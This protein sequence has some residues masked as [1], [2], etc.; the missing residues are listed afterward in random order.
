MDV[1]LARLLDETVQGRSQMTH[2]LRSEIKM[3]AR[4][5]ARRRGRAAGDV[6]VVPRDGPGPARAAPA[7]PTSG[8]ASSMRCRR[9]S[10]SIIFLLVVFVLAQF[11][12]NQLLQGKDTQLQSLEQAIAELTDQLNLEQATS[13]E[14]RLSVAQLS[15]DLQSALAE[16][17]DTAA[18]LAETE[19]ERDEFRDQLL[20]LEDQQAQLTQTLNEL[21]AGSRR[22]PSE[23]EA[24]L[25]RSVDLRARLQEELRESAPDRHH[26]PGDASRPSSRS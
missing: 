26:R 7:S 15:S 22:A 8:R 17:D 12:L 10:W 19:A 14:L 6:G 9:C 4:T 11:F 2:E 13:A 5:I 3:V 21:R 20:L 25:E 23:L 16:R 24:E 1:Y 18:L